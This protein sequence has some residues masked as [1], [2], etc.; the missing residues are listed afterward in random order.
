MSSPPDS[1]SPDVEK[2][3]KTQSATDRSIDLSIIIPAYNE[4]WRLPSTLIDIIDF[5]DTQSRSYEIIV[6]DDGSTDQTEETVRKFERMR[7]CIRHIRLPQNQGKGHAVRTGV[8]NSYGRLVLFTDADGATSIREL[9]RLEEALN[10]GADIAIGSRA[11]SSSQTSVQTSFHRRYL[12]RAFNFFVNL[13]VLPDVEDT[14]CGFKLFRAPAAQFLFE[15]QLSNG[16]SFDVEIL[17]IARKVGLSTREVA[18]NWTNVPG[19]KVNLVRDSVMMALDMLRFRLRHRGL[20][21]GTYAAFL[22][23][24]KQ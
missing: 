10:E 19:S 15:R 12:G 2:W 4:Q 21:P 22:Q 14:Q 18:I 7:P 24:Q 5:L 1:Q 3:L 8:L 23:G 11:V 9:G 17:L 6:V 16:F 13:L 20:S